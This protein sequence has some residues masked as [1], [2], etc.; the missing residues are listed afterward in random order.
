MTSLGLPAADDDIDIGRIELDPA[1]VDVIIRRWEAET[2]HLAVRA[3]NCA[4]FA[5][6]EFDALEAAPPPL[7][8][9]APHSDEASRD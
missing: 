9:S 5:E 1:Y 4:T 7:A 8:L 3:D 2:G 6:A